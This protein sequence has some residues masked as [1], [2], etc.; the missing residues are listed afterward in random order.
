MP[1]SYPQG[2]DEIVDYII[3]NND[4]SKLILDVGPGYGAYGKLLNKTYKI[5]C[6]EIFEKYISD[7]S[8][9]SIYN[10]VHVGDIC[11]FDYSKYDLI[12][13]GDVL[14][15]INTERAIELI[16]NMSQ[17]GKRLVVAVPYEYPQGEWGGN[18]YE[19]HLQ[20]DLTPSI[21]NDRYP[22]L[23]LKFDFGVYGYYTN[24]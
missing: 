19:A 17:S 18:V 16:E 5:D 7:Y 12:I 20:S 3:N 24:F 8:L 21:M 10:N 1:G 6:V 9:S 13:M 2:K 15:H 11:E 14:E 4:I 22:T 23:K